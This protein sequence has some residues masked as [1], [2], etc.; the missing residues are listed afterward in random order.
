[1]V[2]PDA[3]LRTAERVVVFLH[4]QGIPSVVIG[5]IALAAHNYVRFTEDVDLGID[6]DLPS[7]RALVIALQKEGFTADLR[8]PD[9]DDPLGGVIDVSGDFGLVQIVNFGNRFPAVIRDALES[10]DLL[11]TP[12][13]HLRIAPLPQLVALKLYAGGSKAKADIVELLRRNPGADLN[14]IRNV[15]QRYRLRGLTTLLQELE[16]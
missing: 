13:G 12:G 16:R 11:V 3:T 7:L 14:E 1:M 5:G 15:C 2:D 9:G 6:A 8:E 10:N 4:G